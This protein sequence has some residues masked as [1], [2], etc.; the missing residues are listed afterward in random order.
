MRR[1][2]II[3]NKQK[4][5]QKKSTTVVFLNTVKMSSCDDDDDTS[6]SL[7]EIDAVKSIR[8]PPRPSRQAVPV[9]KQAQNNKN[10]ARSL[11]PPTSVLSLS[12]DKSSLQLCLN[13]SESF[14][15]QMKCCFCKLTQSTDTS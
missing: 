14:V 11:S 7:E 3:D 4:C 13:V 12:G 6:D 10:A 8:P 2:V 15:E 1:E 9:A 5:D